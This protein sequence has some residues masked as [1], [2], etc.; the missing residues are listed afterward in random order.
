M[1]IQKL[2]HSPYDYEF[3]VRG[4]H[5]TTNL[6]FLNKILKRMLKGYSPIICICGGQRNGKS[7]IAVWI[8]YLVMKAFSKR[9]DWNKNAVYD[10][11]ET[12][13]KITS[14]SEEIF[15]LDEASSS[16]HKREWFKRINIAF[17]KIIITQG[18]KT[19]CYIFVSPFVN[20]IDKSFTKHFDFIVRV[21]TRGNIK[22]FKVMKRFD[23]MLENRTTYQIHQDDVKV[24]MKDVPK[25]LWEDYND[26]SNKE[27][28]RIERLLTQEFKVRNAE[29]K[30]KDIKSVLRSV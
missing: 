12:T 15:M 20:D 22:V 24:F 11:I 13:R 21:Q 17:S 18:R 5:V 26:F 16:F 9:I 8:S 1:P 6:H 3:N 14:L 2:D 4:K 10:P 27:K 25:K 28:D 30:I 7:F 29:E 19:L 23:S